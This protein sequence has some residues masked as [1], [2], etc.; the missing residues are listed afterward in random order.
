MRTGKPM[1]L[2]LTAGCQTR[3][4]KVSR[5]IRGAGAG[6]EEKLVGAD[7]VDL[8]VVR[9]RVEPVVVDA[10]GAGFVVLVVGLGDLA[11]PG[12]GSASWRLR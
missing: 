2:A 12:G 8:D 10:E 6:G 11:L 4:R 1:P 9:H 3:V 5:E 7:A